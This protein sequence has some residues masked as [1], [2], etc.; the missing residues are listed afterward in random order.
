MSVRIAHVRS[1]KP[2]VSLKKQLTNSRSLLEVWVMVSGRRGCY[3]VRNPAR[4]QKDSLHP[5]F[6]I[7]AG[8]LDKKKRDKD[9]GAFGAQSPPEKQSLMVLFA[10]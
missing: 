3:T 7:A 6:A 2:R 9:S 1:K 8:V 5:S 4:G 10:Q